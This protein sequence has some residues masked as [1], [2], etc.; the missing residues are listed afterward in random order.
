AANL[1]GEK[2]RFPSEPG[3]PGFVKYFNPYPYRG[4]IEFKSEEDASKYYLTLLREQ[5][6]FE[7]PDNIAAIFQET[8]VGSNGI[9]IPPK[10]WLEGV[11]ALCDEYEIMMVCDEVMSGWGRTGE[12]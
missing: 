7:G 5:I 2:R 10:G 4:P 3:I 8:V 1:T 11:R 9:L 12:W 6:E